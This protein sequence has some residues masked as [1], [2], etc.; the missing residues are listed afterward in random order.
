M[1][2]KTLLI[3]FLTLTACG[4]STNSDIDT[5]NL[6]EFKSTEVIVTDSA[7]TDNY[8]CGNDIQEPGEDCDDNN[9]A[10]CIQCNSPRR[11]FINSTVQFDALDIKY[12]NLDEMCTEL[13]VLNSFYNEFTWKAWISKTD[14]SIKDNLYNS[15]GYYTSLSGSI[16]AYSFADLTDG[17]LNDVLIYDQDGIKQLDKDVWTGTHWDGSFAYENCDNWSDIR[18][19]GLMGRTNTIGKDWTTVEELALCSEKKFF[20]CIEDEYIVDSQY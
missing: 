7:T 8:I 1:N 14:L 6:T 19:F 20:Y 9:D 13:A 4:D 3:T 16:L 10:H 15:L 5:G 17:T 2:I 11:I 18:A 12:E